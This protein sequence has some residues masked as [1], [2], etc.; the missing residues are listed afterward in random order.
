MLLKAKLGHAAL[1][2]GLFGPGEDGPL[3]ERLLLVIQ[4]GK[5]L[6]GKRNSGLG[7]I[8]CTQ[9]LLHGLELLFVILSA[10]QLNLFPVCIEQVVS[11]KLV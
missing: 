2:L 11:R 4:A 3:Q 10:A 5:N 1:Q 6:L 9:G 8:V 7:G